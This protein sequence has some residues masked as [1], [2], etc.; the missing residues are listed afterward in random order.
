MF[1]HHFAGSAR[2]WRPVIDRLADRYRCV[3]PDL[4]GFGGSDAPAQGY[5]VRDYADDVAGLVAT[6]QLEAYVLV[7]HSMGG[8][9]AL[10]LAARQPRGLT[11]LVLVAPS[12]PTPEPMSADARISQVRAHGDRA[13]AHDTVRRITRTPLSTMVVEQLVDDSVRS[14]PQAWRAW[15]E[16]GSQEDISAAMPS[17]TV[18]TSVVAGG[19]DPVIPPALLRRELLA[20]L[21]GA[22]M[23]VVPSVGH[24]LPLE[25][26][27]ETAA[28]I[29]AHAG[30]H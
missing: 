21:P 14:A 30:P 18:P 29:A 15:L 5:A 10:A 1:L 13:A 3:A 25:A 22:M 12:P 6:M 26:T 7:G 19:D 17:I 8:K 23:I 24:L 27:A 20:H 2:T 11:A 4:R 16:H 9:I 28:H